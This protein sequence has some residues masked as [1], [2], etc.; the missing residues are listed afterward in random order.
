VVGGSILHGAPEWTPIGGGLQY[1]DKNLS[2]HG[3]QKI[4]VKFTSGLILVKAKGTGIGMTPLAVT[5]PVKAQLVNLDNGAC[6]ESAFPTA[7]K[8]E[9][10]KVIAVQP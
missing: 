9:A 8:N 10:D 1:K 5:F 6:W 4:K 3:I 7:K 2:R